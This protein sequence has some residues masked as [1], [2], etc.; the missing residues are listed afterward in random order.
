MLQQPCKVCG[1][2]LQ[3]PKHA[4]LVGC[5]EKIRVEPTSAWDRITGMRGYVGSLDP[6][7]PLILLEPGKKFHVEPSFEMGCAPHAGP[8][9]SRV[10]TDTSAHELSDCF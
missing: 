10:L 2:E 6:E 9:V 4:A 5:E 8:L 1:F 3:P 7:R